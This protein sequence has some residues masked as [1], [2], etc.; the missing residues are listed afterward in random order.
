MTPND[1]WNEAA[2]LF[3]GDT[4][5]QGGAE[6]PPVPSPEP[7]SPPTPP[8]APRPEPAPEPD[9]GL[10]ELE[11]LRA[12][13]RRRDPALRE[14][15]PEDPYS[16]DS[17]LLRQLE[18]SGWMRNL[19][20]LH[21]GERERARQDAIRESEEAAGRGIFGTARDVVAEAPFWLGEHIGQIPGGIV[22]GIGSFSQAPDVAVAAIE[23]AQQNR[24]RRLIEIADIIDRDG[25]SGPARPGEVRD[26]VIMSF[27]ARYLMMTADERRA[28]R[29]RVEAEIAG[30]APMPIQ[31]RPFFQAGEWLQERGRT[32]IPHVPGYDEQSVASQLGRGLGSM[33]GGL[34]ARFATGPIGAAAFFGGMGMGEAT[35][36]AVQFDRRERAA[37]RP[38]ITQEQIV[39]AGLLG[40]GPG[41]TDI[42]P[43]EALLHRLNAPGM[44]PQAR[45]ALARVIATVGG[46]V[47]GQ[48][49][50]E[51]VQEGGQ[52]IIQNFIAQQVYNADQNLLEEAWW[53]AVIGAGVGAESELGRMALSRL[54]RL[55]GS[56]G[57]GRTG[58]DAPDALDTNSWIAAQERAERAAAEA[59]AANCGDAWVVTSSKGRR[60]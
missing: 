34:G 3:G 29:T 20:T 43:V 22:T 18:E 13:E 49:L 9:P 36:R 50:T 24:R 35:E 37:G 38:G 11:Q 27:V 17:P 19:R 21:S 5:P 53:N 30:G 60:G 2:W 42:L 7:A 48:A 1:D 39:L 6:P 46:R 8:P 55:R 25:Q 32:L 28:E 16:G 41:A 26:P 23:H 45:R 57:G 14:Q 56:R 51:G 10:V 54:A 44:T 52:Q 58:T 33:I 15:P 12:R 31:N 47:F 59:Y 4:A 40:V